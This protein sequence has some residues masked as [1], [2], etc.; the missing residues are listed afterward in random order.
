MKNIFVYV[1]M[2]IILLLYMGTM[3]SCNDDILNEVPKSFF[4]PEVILTNKAGFETSLTAIHARLR[5]AYFVTND[6]TTNSFILFHEGTDIS[7]NKDALYND[8]PQTVT[9][10]MPQAA[11]IWNL[12]Y[13]TIL[14]T[15]NM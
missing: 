14:P 15:A 10:T 1:R 13:V 7:M 9:P 12:A 3:F 5:N 11:Y 4:N 8:Y 6:N 2:N